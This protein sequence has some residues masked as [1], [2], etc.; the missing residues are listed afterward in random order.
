[1]SQVITPPQ[2]IGPM[3]ALSLMELNALRQGLE[4]AVALVLRGEASGVV[5]LAP[6]DNGCRAWHAGPTGAAAAGACQLTLVRTR[7]EDEMEIIEV[8]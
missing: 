7:L 2:D 4:E 3:P 5:I 6:R 8:A 1:M